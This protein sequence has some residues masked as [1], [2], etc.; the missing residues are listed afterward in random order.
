MKV[1]SRAWPTK[2]RRSRSL[3]LLFSFSCASSSSLLF[4]TALVSLLMVTHSVHSLAAPGP[5]ATAK[6]LA[7]PA[8]YNKV[9]ETKM[10][11]ENLTRQQAEDEY[12]Q[13]LENPPFYYA[14]DKKEEYYKSL[15]YKDLFEGMIGEAEK[16]GKGEE[17]RGRI[18]KFR[19]QSKFKAA[20]VL[21]TFCV[22]FYLARQEYWN[23]P[24]NFLPG[25]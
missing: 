21:I 14:L 11:Q 5:I 8:G 12:N 25:I 19:L 17:V 22:V 6:K 24:D 18:E 16:E 2:T 7:D 23:D 20:A 9:I 3:A 4:G 15:G 1:S 10:K 13:F